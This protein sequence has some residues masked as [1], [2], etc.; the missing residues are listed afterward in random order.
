MGA[1]IAMVKVDVRKVEAGI[2]NI[3]GPRCRDVI[4]VGAGGVDVMGADVDMVDVGVFV[5]A[6]PG[7]RKKSRQAQIFLARLRWMLVL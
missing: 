4:G 2:V 6:R 1:E 7:I 3:G 5:M